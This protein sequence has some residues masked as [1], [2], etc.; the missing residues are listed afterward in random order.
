MNRQQVFA[1]V[2]VVGLSFG[3]F[4]YMQKQ[5]RLIDTMDYEFENV[6]LTGI[7]SQA[8][9]LSFD[10]VLENKSDLDLKINNIDF[11]VLY[12]NSPVGKVNSVQSYLVQRRSTQVVPL[13][14][15]LIRSEM[16]PAIQQ[17]FSN[18]Q[19]LL[20]GRIKIAGTM[21]V[22]ADFFTTKDF[23][24][25]YEDTTANLVGYSISSVTNILG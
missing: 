9:T 7:G 2:A 22:G 20:S 24:F 11:D 16:K 25:E 13:T 8:I 3:L 14:L 10:L 19:N 12:N 17:A 15:T 18:V 5:T 23:P 21:D 4:A 6:R 1:L